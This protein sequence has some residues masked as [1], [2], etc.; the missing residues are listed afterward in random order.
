MI[1]FIICFFLV[2]I[3]TLTFSQSQKDSSSFYLVKEIIT[4]LSHDS[5]KGRAVGSIEEKKSLSYIETKFKSLTNKKLKI[6]S[7]NFILDST[8]INSENSYFYINKHKKQTILISAHYDHIGLGGKLSLS[9]RKDQI[10]NGADDNA[11]GVALLLS[12]VNEL[13]LAKNSK[14]NYLIV[15][16]SAHEVGLFGSENFYNNLIES[17]NKFKPIYLAINFDMVGR[18]DSDLKKYNC[19]T[20]NDS[21]ITSNSTFLKDN[22]FNLNI[23][24]DTIKLSNLDTHKFIKNEFDCMNF[25]SGIHID[26]HSVNDD[27]KY[28]NYEGIL[29]FRKYILAYIS[30]L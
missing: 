23:T 18:M 30:S 14:Y 3:P 19:F 26:Y 4:V 29:L 15:F 27:E 25:T 16:Y 22:G 24:K 11:S 20:S 9:A 1:Q 13:I 7:F 6:Q 12:L 2:L 21:L 17:K 28:I 5:L 10:H 8:T